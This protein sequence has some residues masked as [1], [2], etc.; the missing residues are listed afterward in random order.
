PR[1]IWLP[2][3]AYRAGLDAALAQYGLTHFVADTH[4]ILNGHPPA[5]GAHL[6]VR[7]PGGPAVFVRDIESSRQVWSSQAGY[8]G[9]AD[10]REFYRDLGY[11]GD[12]ASIRPCL[13]ADGIRRNI[14]VKYHRVTGKVDLGAKALYN[15]EWAQNKAREHA[16]HYLFCRQQQILGL[17]RVM[18]D[19]PIV[20]APYDAELF[21][22]W[23]FEGPDFLEQFFRHAQY[24][25]GDY[26]PITLSGYL[27]R[28]PPRHTCA[29]SSSSWG[30]E[31][32]YGVWLNNTNDW[33]YRHL[34]HAEERM[35]RLCKAHPRA[36]RAMRAA[37]NQAARELLLA[38][39]SDWAFIMAN[40]TSVPYAHRRTREHITR[41]HALC[42]MVESRAPDPQA[43]EA[44]WRLDPI[45]PD[46]NYRDW[47]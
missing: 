11:D 44:I 23:W 41:F 35:V 30:N 19:P 38:Q 36:A 45:F 21:G 28:H 9:D 24:V 34:H 37:L 40:N 25:R 16:R 27:Q 10:Y 29:P 5:Q 39:S 47:R 12:Y 6:P 15:H 42:D 8:P 1:G 33:I 4:A 22:H 2:E 7:T 17:S 14:G 3:C 18:S 43:I 26:E 20:V 32:Y 13:H 31:G 46:I